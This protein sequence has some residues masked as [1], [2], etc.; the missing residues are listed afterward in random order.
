MSFSLKC[1]KCGKAMEEG[2][3]LEH[4]HGGMRP[5]SWLEGPPQKS[6]WTGL[7]IKGRANVPIRTFRCTRC[8][9]LE[10]YAPDP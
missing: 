4:T 1:P 2:Y 9:F 3:L 7:A 6:F 10:S 5:V 8:G